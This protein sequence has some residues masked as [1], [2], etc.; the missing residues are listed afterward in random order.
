MKKKFTG[1]LSIA[2]ILVLTGLLFINANN[3]DERKAIIRLLENE[4][5][6]F[7]D[8]DFKA[9][10][11]NWVKDEESKFMVSGMEYY[12]VFEGWNEIG[13][14]FQDHM[15][16]KKEHNV[17]TYEDPKDFEYN[18][19]VVDDNMA[20][21]DLTQYDKNREVKDQR[22][23]ILQR[24]NNEWKIKNIN[25]IGVDSYAEGKFVVNANNAPEVTHVNLN[26]FPKDKVFP[27]I[28]GWGGMCVDINNAPAG[29]EFTPL[30]EGLKNDHC[31]VPHWGYVVKGAIRMDYE[32][33]TSEVFREGEA[34]YMKPGHTGG[35]EEDL[36]LVSFGPEE[37]IRHLV[38]H[39]E[40][41][42]AEMQK[43]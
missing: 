5:Q 8:N 38:E 1:I 7:N 21:V 28:E 40:N 42:V 32:D 11:D 29:T 12:Y 17:K 14:G 25:M 26:D 41:K 2:A 36:L 18:H 3:K 34:F 13:K 15:A 30:L 6:T 39:F 9:Y 35:V 4:R 37:G 10:S 24:V 43:Q 33:G 16:W 19:I 31:Q 27:M 23:Y 22:T 20:W